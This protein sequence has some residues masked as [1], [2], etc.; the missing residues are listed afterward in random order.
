MRD[1]RTFPLLRSQIGD[2]RPETIEVVAIS[3]PTESGPFD[4][5]GMQY[6]DLL[7]PYRALEFIYIQSVL[8]GNVFVVP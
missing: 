6:C 8:H 3:L 7:S 5:N 2:Q 4:I 1:F